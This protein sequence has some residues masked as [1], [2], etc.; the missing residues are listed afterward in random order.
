MTDSGLD[1]YDVRAHVRDIAEIVSEFPHGLM[2][3]ANE[4]DHPT[5]SERV[6][7]PDYLRR[8]GAEEVAPHGV[9]WAVG[10]S[11]IDELSVDTGQYP[12]A[13]GGFCHVHLARRTG[14]NYP[15]Y[16]EACRV[17]EQE[18]VSGKHKA[19]VMDGEPNK[20]LGGTPFYYTLGILERGFNLGGVCH[21]EDGLQARPLAGA[22]LE[23]GEVLPSREALGTPTTGRSPSTTPDG[24]G[25]RSRRR[26]SWTRLRAIRTGKPSGAS[27]RRLERR[28]GDRRRR[29]AGS[30]ERRDRVGEWLA[31]GGTPGRGPEY[32]SPRD[33]AGPA[34]ATP[35]LRCS[36]L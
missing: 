8:L 10:A 23:Q 29:R 11:D 26:A 19:P 18:S 9:L 24:T 36:A 13:G 16:Q 31:P 22:D 34:S 15:W 6:H 35:R 4:Y 25:R 33:P 5:Q 17:R 3:I 28:H 32:P 21:T 20:R 12:G 30:G 7:D 2:C 14:P 27:T 1:D